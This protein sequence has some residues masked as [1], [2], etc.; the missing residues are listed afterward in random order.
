MYGAPPFRQSFPETT[1]EPAVI[2]LGP[3]AMPYPGPILAKVDW[4]RLM[5]RSTTFVVQTDV[6]TG[7]VGLPTTHPSRI[8]I[9]MRLKAPSLWGIVESRLYSMPVRTLP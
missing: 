2:E 7:N 8:W 4:M 9:L 3:S 5:S 1:D 6:P